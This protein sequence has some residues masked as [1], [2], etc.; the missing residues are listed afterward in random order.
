ML[1]DS[2]TLG[3]S[4]RQAHT[5]VTPSRAVVNKPNIRTI[6][7]TLAGAALVAA[8]IIAAF[9]SMP[10]A[11]WTLAFQGWVAGLGAL[12]VLVF[13]AAYVVAVICLAPAVPLSIAAGVAYGFWAVPLAL[14]SATVGA[15]LAFLIARHVAGPA[16]HRFYAHHPYFQAVDRAVSEEGWKVVGLL[17]LSPLLPFS[18]Q[19]YI[20]GITS[21]GFT[22]FVLATF[23]GIIPGACLFVYIG[24]IGLEA[25]MGTT[26]PLQWAFFGLGLLATLAVAWIIVRKAREA[27]REMGVAPVSSRPSGAARR[28]EPGPCS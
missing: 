17:R 25:A 9:L 24:K 10:L 27:L 2:S 16:A 8:A 6:A 4:Q 1:E 7:W 18:L 5:L 15:A 14:V 28:A 11:K 3:I 26:G 22:P 13:F 19:S 20:L 12:G 21:V 23:V